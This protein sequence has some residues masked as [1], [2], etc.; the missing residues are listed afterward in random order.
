M[1][2]RKGIITGGN[3]IIDFVK[4]ID[5]YPQENALANILEEKSGNGG[6]P[7]N[8]V[9]AFHKMRVTFPLE[10]IG[11]VGDDEKGRDIVLECEEMG[12]DFSQLRVR[13]GCGT[14]YTDVMTVAAT[15]KRTFFHH[16]GASAHLAASDFDFSRTRAKIFHLGYLLLLDELDRMDEEGRTG[17]SRVLEAASQAGLLTSADIVSEQ[18]DRYRSI[19]PASLPFVDILFLNELEARGLTGIEI[20]DTDG[21][22]RLEKAK[23]AAECIMELGVRQ[24]VIFHFPVGAIAFSRKGDVYSQPCVTFPQQLIRGT[25]GAGDA[26]AAGVLAAVHDGWSMEQALKSGVCVAAVSLLSPAASDG[27]LPW[28]QCM[29]FGGKWGF[30]SRSFE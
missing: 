19:V 14:S 2:I 29:D 30:S 18:S 20:L 24:W 5:T 8:L 9:K 15:G 12:V 21:T 23:E 3:W 26:F 27:I 10:G 11:V 28:D 1:D 16:R 6:A 7:F 22:A 17:A 4:L 13:P 25:V